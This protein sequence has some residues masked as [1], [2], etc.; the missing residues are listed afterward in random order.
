MGSIDNGTADTLS[1]KLQDMT[2]ELNFVQRIVGLVCDT[3]VT[4]TGFHG[5]ACSK[6]EMKIQKELLRLCCRHHIP[7]IVLKKVCEL[8]LGK[9]SNSFLTHVQNVIDLLESL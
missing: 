3:E 4:N 2:I 8:L 7:E 5:G 6:Y 9:S 1:E